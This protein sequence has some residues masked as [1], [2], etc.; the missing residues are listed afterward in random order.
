MRHGVDYSDFTDKF[1]EDAIISRLLKETI[2]YIEEIIARQN[3]QIPTS[4]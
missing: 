3:P 1:D 4:S 2:S